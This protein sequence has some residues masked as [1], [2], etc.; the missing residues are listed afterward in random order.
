MQRFFVFVL[1]IILTGISVDTF[2]QEGENINPREVRVSELSDD[3]I[4]RLYNEI[5]NRGLSEQ[6]ATSMAMARGFTRQQIRQLRQRF[7]E[8]EQ[9]Q[10]DADTAR[11]ETD[12]ISGQ[13]SRKEE[14]DADEEEKEIFGFNFFNSERLTFEPGVNLPVSKSYVLGAGDQISIDVWGASQ[15][16]YQLTVDQSGNINIPDAGT[17]SLQGLSLEEAREK[18]FDK[19]ALIYSDLK[20]EQPETFANIYLGQIRPINVH[21]IGEVFAPGSFTLPGSATAFNALYLAG[22]PNSQGSFREIKVIRDGEVIKKMDV[23]KYL[24]DGNGDV[25]VTLRDDDVVMVPSYDKRVRMEGEFKRTGIFEG[26]ENET[27]A[28]MLRYSGGFTDKA[29]SHRIEMFRNDSRQTKFKNIPASRFE[30]E[31]V[32]NGDSIVAGEITDRIEDRV[33]IEGAVRRPG[34]Y[35]LEE[36]LKLSELLEMAEG[37]REDAYMQR[38]QVL[39]LDENLQMKNVAFDVRELVSGEFDMELQREDIVSIYSI[40]SLRQEQ[41][42]TIRGEVQRPDTYDYRDGMTLSDLIVLAGGFRERAASSYIEVS[43]RLTNE[44]AS[45]YSQKTGHLFQFSISR[46]LELDD[47]DGNFELKPFDQVSVRKAPGYVDEGSVRLDGEVVYAGDYTLNNR[48]ER[49]SSVIERAGGITPDAYPEGAMLTREVQVDAKQKRL[50][51]QLMETDS[52]LQFDDMGFEVLAVDLKEVLENPESREDVILQE[53]DE[54]YIPRELQTVKISGEVLNPVTTPY[55]KGKGLKYYVDQGGGFAEEA[56]KRKAYVVYPNGRASATNKVFLMINDYPRVLPG[57]EIVVPQKP[58]KEGLPA[59]AWVSI[60]S[61]V[62]SMA[63]TVV[64]IVNA[65]N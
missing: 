17:V 39:R 63:L 14:I 51:E 45:E 2:A 31:G 29:Y 1:L 54:L 53:G 18:I 30:E 58:E 56:R 47:E 61:S 12:T 9:T 24:I 44:E 36:D 49:L 34:N 19:L 50:R 60:G 41:T 42:M 43:R 59:T 37:L 4:R 6:Q 13:M 27:V 10:E 3:Q 25:N 8:L 23:Y 5:E 64:S 15:Q 55:V 16:S 65:L 35:E 7:E 38:G 46:N 20:G 26:K 62:A 22:G 57:S 11:M 40:D 52:T 48:G 33:M 28:D 32:Q 21:V